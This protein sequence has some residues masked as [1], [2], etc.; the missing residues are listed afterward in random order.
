MKLEEVLAIQNKASGD[1]VIHVLTKELKEDSCL[2]IHHGTERAGMFF[3]TE[4]GFFTVWQFE[5]KIRPIRYD[6]LKSLKHCL[7]YHKT[8]KVDF[9]VKLIQKAIKTV[10]EKSKVRILLDSK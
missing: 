1:R 9:K 10:E 8:N 6:D 7:K 4:E 5:N 3:E 2:L